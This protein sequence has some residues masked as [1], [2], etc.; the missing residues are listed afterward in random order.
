[1]DAK[2]ATGIRSSSCDASS[3]SLRIHPREHIPLRRF[4]SAPE[5]ARAHVHAFRHHLEGRL[6][7]VFVQWRLVARLNDLLQL[8]WHRLND[9]LDHVHQRRHRVIVDTN[10]R[11]LRDA[12][13]PVE[14]R[15]SRR[16]TASGIRSDRCGSCCGSCPT[17]SAA[18][19][20]QPVHRYEPSSLSYEPHAAAEYFL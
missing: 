14:C 9:A 16:V 13:L 15:T 5:C 2:T 6:V 7:A 19:V 3:S 20:P 10:V 1:M 11:L 12:E 17:E 8:C 18:H 4:Q